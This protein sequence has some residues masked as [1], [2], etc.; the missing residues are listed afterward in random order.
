MIGITVGFHRHF[1]H[2][3]F[4]AQGGVRAALAVLGSMSAQGTLAY[5]VSVHRQHHAASDEDGDPHSPWP[6]NGERRMHALWRAHASWTIDHPHPETWKLARDLLGNRL[7]WSVNRSYP[8]WV[9]SGLVA[10]AALSAIVHHSLLG[11][12]Y[13]FLCGGL[14][15]IFV[16]FHITSSVNS[17]CHLVGSRPYETRDQSRNNSWLALPT[18]GESWHNNHHAFPTS[19][20]MGFAWWQIDISAAVIRGLELAGLAHD[21]KRVTRTAQEDQQRSHS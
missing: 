8:I 17:V 9:A 3:S 21:V 11:A 6:R 16:V 12:L 7:L 18:L 13:G 5:W 4:K 19:A 15:R 10:P 1:A 14:A 2:G 20:R